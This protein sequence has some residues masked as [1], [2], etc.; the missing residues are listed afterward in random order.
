MHYKTHAFI[1]QIMITYS[2]KGK[3][4]TYKKKQMKRLIS[5]LENIFLNEGTQDLSSIGRKQL[6]G[7]WHRTEGEKNET[8]RAKYCILKRFFCEY[9]LKVT[10]PEPK[11]C[12]VH[13]N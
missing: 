2:H 12:D 7:Y 13:N 6:I 3:K 4:S 1:R 9:N 5:I 10:V 8:R 11:K